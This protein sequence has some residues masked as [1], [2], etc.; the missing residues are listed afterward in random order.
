MKNDS[1]RIGEARA[2]ILRDAAEQ[3]VGFSINGMV[4]QA[5]DLWVAV[6]LPVYLS[7]ARKSRE[8]IGR[9]VRQPVAL[10]EVTHT[11]S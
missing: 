7:A 4:K 5:I 1:V 6:E 8:N 10:H 11:I 9:K 3:I 2:A